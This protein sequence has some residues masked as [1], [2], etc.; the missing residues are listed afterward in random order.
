MSDNSIT[1]V[2]KQS[3]Y[4]NADERARELLSWLVSRNIV[5]NSLSDCILGKKGGYE[6][7][8]GAK[9]ITDEPEYLPYGLITNGLEITTERQVFDNG[10]NGID[11]IICPSCQGDILENEWDLSEWSDGRTDNLICPI[12]NVEAEINK[13]RF[14]PEWGFSNLGFT[15]WNWP[16]FTDQFIEEFKHKLG[17]EIVVVYRHL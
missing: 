3:N 2:P 16:D 15:F 7:A 13:F 5:K 6:I 10:G 11:E 4:P 9:E 17:T 1:I 12:C 8:E 14:E